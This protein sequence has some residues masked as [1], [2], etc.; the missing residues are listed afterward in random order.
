MAD[1]ETIKLTPEALEALRAAG[2]LDPLK[3]TRFEPCLCGTLLDYM[4]G[5][6]KWHSGRFSKGK[7]IA[8]GINYTAVVCDDCT[9]EY[10]GMSRIVCLGCK[11]LM[12]F[13]K[14]GKQQTGFIFERDRHYHILSCP[15]CDQESSATPVIEH[16]NFCKENGIPTDTNKD[17]LQEIEQKTLQGKRDADKLRAEFESSKQSS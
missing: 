1:D 3:M 4:T 5:A 10:K 8:D 17:L 12:G 7:Q 6:K 16:E 11:S 9:K 13:Y 14:P 15:R 2:D